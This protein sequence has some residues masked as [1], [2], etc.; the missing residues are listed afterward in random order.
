MYTKDQVEDQLRANVRSAVFEREFV[1]AF[2]KHLKEKQEGATKTYAEKRDWKEYRLQP[3]FETIQPFT[4]EGDDQK[5]HL[6][7][8][9]AFLKDAAFYFD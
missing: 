4:V 2:N 9:N 1:L 8:W 6:A 3:A 5:F 7:K